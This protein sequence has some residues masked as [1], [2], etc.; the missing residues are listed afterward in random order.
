MRKIAMVFWGGKCRG[1]NGRNGLRCQTE[2]SL[3]A[4]GCSHKCVRRFIICQI[5]LIEYSDN[6]DIIIKLQIICAN[7]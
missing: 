2:G 1:H 5:K 6:N 4:W 7:I 3:P